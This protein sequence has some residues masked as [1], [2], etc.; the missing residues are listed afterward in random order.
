MILWVDLHSANPGSKTGITNFEKSEYEDE[1][2]YLLNVS[3]VCA[4]HPPPHPAL[5]A[6][7]PHPHAARLSTVPILPVHP[8]GLRADEDCHLRP[9]MGCVARH[10][11]GRVLPPVVLGRSGRRWEQ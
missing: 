7:V 6:A 9:Q 1:M 2:P 8:I 11:A 5:N 10:S 3:Q 4:A